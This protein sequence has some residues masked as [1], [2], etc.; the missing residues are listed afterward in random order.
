MTS[1]SPSNRH[2]GIYQSIAHHEELTQLQCNVQSI[3]LAIAQPLKRHLTIHD[4]PFEKLDGNP[5]HD[6]LQITQIMEADLNQMLAVL[7]GSRLARLI[8]KY[9]IRHQAQSAYGK[10][11]DTIRIGLSKTIINDYARINYLT[12]ILV[13][14]DASAAFN[15]LTLQGE[16][17]TTQKNGMAKKPVEFLA[18]LIRKA[19]HHIATAHGVSAKSY[20]STP[21][22]PVDG[23]GQGGANSALSYND[24]SDLFLDCMDVKHKGNA[25]YLSCCA[26]DGRRHNNY[27]TY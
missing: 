17:L 21:E 11:R 10:G 15:R 13:D 4:T 23:P 20:T 18:T 24:S 27:H 22:T 25:S 8:D 2:I 12:N 6:K 19:K 1:S 5:R 14:L 9:D 16:K 26:S 3:C 7:W